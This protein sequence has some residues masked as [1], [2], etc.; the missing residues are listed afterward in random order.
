MIL[1]P[2]FF[3]PLNFHFKLR[4]I[5][6][7]LLTYGLYI[8]VGGFASTIL[9]QTDTLMITYFL[10]LK[11][12]G[13]Y[14]AAVPL[15]TLL[16]TLISPITAVLLSRVS[17]L[18]AQQKKYEVESLFLLI[19]KYVL[20]LVLPITLILALFADLIV[21]LLFTSQYVAAVHPLVILSFAFMISAISALFSYTLISVGEA[22]KVMYIVVFIAIINL[23]GNYF[24]ISLFNITGAAISTLMASG[25]M[26]VML[27]FY[28]GQKIVITIKYNLLFKILFAAATFL[29]SIY[30]CRK[31]IETNYLLEA[32]LCII[33]SGGIYLLTLFIL[34][35][36]KK[37][38]VM[39]MK[40]IIRLS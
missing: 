29:L 21:K 5:Y 30:L 36:V 37:E 17:N 20:I 7:E 12:V 19:Q 26:F 25:V 22:K 23:I 33:I 39:F 9:L 34:Q 16:T 35:V 27:Y 32:V 10:G 3:I 28:L 14:Q 24:L 11:E 13:L 2:K 18:W 40:K 15:A 4:L 31:L 38:D 6:P 1:N 8:V